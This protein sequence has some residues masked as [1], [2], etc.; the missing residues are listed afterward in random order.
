MMTFRST[1]QTACT[2]WVRS[3]RRRG[4]LLFKRLT[5]YHIILLALA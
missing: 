2:T 3:F 4:V 1:M 5:V